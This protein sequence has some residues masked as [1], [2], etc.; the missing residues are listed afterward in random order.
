MKVCGDWIAFVRTK[1]EPNSWTPGSGHICN[2]HFSADSY[3]G[4]GAKIAG[5]SAKLVLKKSAVPSI[6]AS[7][8]PK[9]VNE[10]RRRK[11]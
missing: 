10:A 8:T 7:P 5:F 3:K 9:Q 6:H 1:R 11:R 2:D 4:F